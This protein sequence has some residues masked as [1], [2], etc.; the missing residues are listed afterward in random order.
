[1]AED[2]ELVSL[3]RGSIG[4]VLNFLLTCEEE[5]SKS[6]IARGADVTFK[7][8]SDIWPFLERHEIIVHTRTIG[9]AKMYSLNKDNRIVG[10]LRKIKH[11]I[12]NHNHNNKG[13]GEIFSVYGFLLLLTLPL[14]GT[15]YFA[16]ND[17]TI[18]V[19]NESLMNITT[20]V[21]NVTNA[22]NITEILVNGTIES[23][24]IPAEEN[25]NESNASS[26]V[27]VNTSEAILNVTTTEPSNITEVSAPIIETNV[28]EI[29]Y[30]HESIVIGQRVQ[31]YRQIKTQG[32]D[33]YTVGLNLP[34]D[35]QDL[36]MIDSIGNYTL[37]NDTLTLSG[38]HDLQMSFTTSPVTVSE[39][40]LSQ[41]PYEDKVTVASNSTLHYSNI[42]VSAKIPEKAKLSIIEMLGKEIIND[43]AYNVTFI[44]TDGNGK[45]DTLTWVVP[46]LSTKEYLIQESGG[47]KIE[48]ISFDRR[49]DC[50]RCGQHKVPS[51]S[52]VNMSITASFDGTLNDVNFTDYFPINW[53]MI[54]SNGGTVESYNSSHNRISW[55]YDSITGSISQW[56]VTQ[57]TQVTHP[58]TKY[59]F[60]SELGNVQSDP[61]MVVVADPVYSMANVNIY[62]VTN[63][64]R[65]S[66]DEVICEAIVTGSGAQVPV[67]IALQYNNG[68]TGGWINVTTSNAL[69][70]S[71]LDLNPTL[72]SSKTASFN[73]TFTVLTMRTGSGNQFRCAGWNGT[74]TITNSSTF[75]MTILT[76]NLQLNLT[77]TS[78]AAVY[79]DDSNDFN[80][81]VNITTKLGNASNVGVYLQWNYSTGSDH[82][83]YNISTSSSA[84][85]YAD[86]A[87]PQYYTN[88]DNI[89]APDSQLYQI[90]AH[91]AG[92]YWFRAYSNSSVYDGSFT[93]TTSAYPLTVTT[94]PIRRVSSVTIGN[95][96]NITRGTTET[97]LYCNVSLSNSGT[98]VTGFLSLQYYNST[99]WYDLN[100]TTAY[101]PK[102]LTYDNTYGTN[103]R[104]FSAIIDDTAYRFAVFGNWTGNNYLLRCNITDQSN[105]AYNISS[106]G[107]LN[108]TAIPLNVNATTDQNPPITIY[109]D[110][111][112][113]FNLTCNVSAYDGNA[114]SVT[115][116]AQWNTSASTTWNNFTR[117]GSLQANDTNVTFSNVDTSQPDTRV[118]E[119]NATAT[120]DYW[121]RCY[122]NTSTQNGLTTNFSNAVPVTVTTAP[123]PA[124]LNV[125]YQSPANGSSQTLSQ[126]STF[127]VT[128]NVTCIGGDCGN[129]TGVLRY[130]NSA[131]LNPNTAVSNTTGAT[132]FSLIDNSLKGWWKF[133][134]GSGQYVNDS[135][136][137]GLNGTL[138]NNSGTDAQDPTRIIG[139][140]GGGLLFNGRNQYVNLTVVGNSFS[141]MQPLSVEVWAKLNN[142][143]SGPFLLQYHTTAGYYGFRLAVD[144]S[145]HPYFDW[146]S[147]GGGVIARVMANNTIGDT[148]WHHIAATDDGSTMKIYIDG[149][150]S[151]TS[152]SG[153]SVW[154]SPMYLF[155]GAF[156]PTYSAPGQWFN[157]SMDNVMVYNRALSSSEVL[158]HYYSLNDN[159]SLNPVSCG[160]MSASSTCQLSWTVNATGTIGTQYWL[161]ANFT[162]NKGN[163]IANDS[164]NFQINITTPPEP[165]VLRSITT[166]RV[167][168]ING[169]DS[170]IK[171]RVNIS[172]SQTETPSASLTRPDGTMIALGLLTYNSTSGFY[173]SNYT[174]N[175]A[176]DNAPGD[177]RIN[178]TFSG[179]SSLNYTSF[180]YFPVKGINNIGVLTSR[181]Q[182]WD[183]YR[184]EGWVQIGFAMHNMMRSAGF[185]NS[186]LL[187]PKLTEDIDLSNYSALIVS[188]LPQALWTENLTNKLRN[189]SNS[190]KLLVV[191]GNITRPMQDYIAVNYTSTQPATINVNLTRTSIANDTILA[192]PWVD[193]NYFMTIPAS[194]A[195]WPSMSEDRESLGNG[196]FSFN[197]SGSWCGYGT[198]CT[199]W[200]SVNDWTVPAYN[201]TGAQVFYNMTNAVG[202]YVGVGM[203]IN[204]SVIYSPLPLSDM[205]G[206]SSSWQY[207][208]TAIVYGQR[209]HYGEFFDVFVNLFEYMLSKNDSSPRSW[210][211][212]EEA[213]AL[214]TMRHDDDFSPYPTESEFMNNSDLNHSINN[215]WMGYYNTS[216]AAGQ[217]ETWTSKGNE[218]GYHVKEGG[219]QALKQTYLQGIENN[220]S[221]TV[222]SYGDHG[223][224]SNERGIGMLLGKMALQHG[225]GAALSSGYLVDGAGSQH[226]SGFL[227]DHQFVWWNNS[228]YDVSLYSPYGTKFYMMPYRQSAGGGVYWNASDPCGMR[229]PLDGDGVYG[230]YYYRRAYYY[231]MLV[232]PQDNLSTDAAGQQTAYLKMAACMSNR[233]GV[234]GNYTFKRYAD[235]L[236]LRGNVTLYVNSSDANSLS[237]IV[238]SPTLVENFTWVIPWKAGWNTTN[239]NITI[240]G[241]DKTSASRIQNASLYNNTKDYLMF[242]TNVSAGQSTITVEK[243]IV[244]PPAA[245]LYNVSIGNV[246]NIYR[247]DTDRDIFCNATSQY[248]DVTANITLQ[249]NNSGT[250]INLN[251]TNLAT[252]YNVTYKNDYGTN[253]RWNEIVSPTGKVVRFAVYAN[254]S[255]T[256]QFRCN[257]STGAVASPTESNISALNTMAIL[258]PPLN[259]SITTVPSGPITIYNDES[260]NFNLT[261]NVSTL[262]GNA[263]SV[264]VYAQY[265]SSTAPGTWTNMTTGT[266]LKANESSPINLIN[267]DN[268]ADQRVFRIN[269]T[270]VGSYS[271]RCYAN[272]SAQSGSNVNWT[273]MVAVS[274][275]EP[276]AFKSLL[277][278]KL[279]YIN[280]TDQAM[281]VRV[282]ITGSTTE[283]VYGGVIRPSGSY[284]NIGQLQYNS[285]S[286]FYETNYT[287]N[288]NLDNLP[289]DYRV[290]VTWSGN[291]YIN[292]TSFLYMPVQGI[293]NIGVL[294][295]RTQIWDAYRSQNLTQIGFAMHELMR[296]AGYLN[297][298]MLSPKLVE[299]ADLSNFSVLIVSHLPLSL[300]TENLTNKLRNFSNEGKLLILFGNISS[301]MYEYVGV[302]Y[303]GSMDPDVGFNLT[304]NAIANSTVL[305]T[306]L[307]DTD[308]RYYTGTADGGGIGTFSFNVSKSFCQWNGSQCLTY[309]AVN[310]WPAYLYNTT[311]APVMYNLTDNAGVFK[312]VG[313]VVNGTVIYSPLPMSDLFGESA[314]WAYN[315]TRMMLG[316]MNN[317]A[318]LFEVLMRIMDYKMSQNDTF[319]KSWLFPEEAYI[320]VTLRHDDACSSDCG[321][322]NNTNM[323]YGFTGSTW[324]MFSNIS[325]TTAQASIYLAEGNEIAYHSHNSLLNQSLDLIGMENAYG[326]TI[327]TI[328]DH[329]DG[330]NDHG[331]DSLLNK[332]TYVH[333]PNAAI[334]KGYQVEGSNTISYTGGF[335]Q[336][337]LFVWWNTTTWDVTLY[338]RLR[339]QAYD[340]SVG[341][342]VGLNNSEPTGLTPTY[343]ESPR[344][345]QRRNYPFVQLVHPEDVLGN[346]TAYDNMV[347]WFASWPG[348]N[349]NYTHKRLNDWYEARANVTYYINVS[350]STEVSFVVKSPILVENFTWIT[351][352]KTDWNTA[353]INI[354]INGADKT[355]ASKI[356]NAS[357]YNGSKDYLMF[358]TNVSAGQSTIIVSKPGAG[359]LYNVTI[360]NVSNIYRGDIDND[361]FCNATSINGNVYANV[362]LQYNNGSIGGWINLNETNKANNVSYI[363]THGTNPSWGDT[364]TTTGT[365]VSFDIYGNR[366]GSGNQFRCNVTLGSAGNLSSNAT[367]TILAPNLQLNLTNTSTATVYADDSNEFNITVNISTQ[368]GN[369][370]NVGV[371][372]QYNTS[373]DNTW[374]NITTTAT[375]ALY[376]DTATPKYYAN[377]DNSTPQDSQLY[378]I[379][380]H[381][382]G[383]YWFR[384]YSN[385]SV[386]DGS[387]TNTTSAYPLTVSATP[388][389]TPPSISNWL[390]NVTNATNYSSTQGYQFN[391]TVIDAGTGVSYVWVEQNFTGTLANVTVTSCG[392]NVYCYNVSPLA[393][394]TTSYYMKWYANDSSSN[395]NL[396]SSDYV[397]YYRVN[398][399]YIPLTLYINGTNGDNTL[400]NY[401]TANFTANFSS[402]YSFN[403]TLYTNL[404]GAW[405]LWDNHVSPLTNYTALSPYVARTGYLIIA[406]FSN[407]NYTYSQAN[408]SLTL[409]Y[410]DNVQPNI[411]SFKYNV[412]N[413]TNYSSAQ[414]YQF[415]ATVTD[416]IAVD[417]VW[418][419]HNFTGSMANY[420]VTTVLGSEYYY[421]YQ[422]LAAGAYYVKWWANDTNNQVNSSDY[423]KY[424]QVNKSYI[425]LTLYIN[426]TN[427]DTSLYNNSNANFT[428]NFSAG[429]SL[430][431]TL[432]TNLTGS[433]ALWDTQNSP[434]ANYTVLSPYQ[435][436]AYLII[437]NFSNQNYT[438]TQAN[439]SLTLTFVSLGNATIVAFNYPNDGT[440][441]ATTQVI[442]FG[443]TPTFYGGNI[444]NCSLYTNR[445]GTWAWTAPNASAITNASLNAIVY[446]FDM[447]GTF[448]WSI[449]CW[450]Q[451]QLNFTNGNRTLTI[452]VPAPVGSISVTYL[453][454]PSPSSQMILQNVS[455][456]VTVNVN[457]SIGDC[458]YVNATMLYNAS[459]SN[460]D[461]A[462]SGT[463]FN[464]SYGNVIM[465]PS[466]YTN[467]GINLWQTPWNATRYLKDD[468]D[469]A[470]VPFAY[471]NASANDWSFLN[472]TY[473]N[474]GNSSATTL[475]WRFDANVGSGGQWQIMLKNFSSS[476]WVTLLNGTATWTNGLNRTSISTANGTIGPNGDVVISF[477]AYSSS[478]A[479]KVYHNFLNT[480][481][482]SNTVNCGYMQQNQNCSVA[483]YVN[484]TGAG[485][486]NLSAIFVANTTTPTTSSGNF[487]VNITTN[488][489]GTTT[490]SYGT[491]MPIE[492]LNFY[493]QG[494]FWVFFNMNNLTEYYVTSTDGMTWSARTAIVPSEGRISQAGFS[495]WTNG[496]TIDYARGYGNESDGLHYRRGTLNS[497]GS[498]SWMAEQ[499][500]DTGKIAF[501]D[502]TI[503]VDSRGYPWI[504]SYSSPYCVIYTYLVNSTVFKSS[505][506]DGTWTTDVTYN[507]TNTSYLP[508]PLPLQNGNV[509]I[510]HGF[511]HVYYPGGIDNVI[512]NGTGFGALENA[513]VSNVSNGYFAR[514][515]AVAVG[516][517]V[518]LVFLN[519]SNGQI[520]YVKRTWGSGWGTEQVL[521]VTSDDSSSPTLT[522]GPA[523]DLYVTWCDNLNNIYYMV[524]NHTTSSWASA[525]TLL[526]HDNSGFPTNDRQ[527]VFYSVTNK[528]LGVEYLKNTVPYTV[529]FAY[530][531]VSNYPGWLNISYQSP[532]TG[533]SQ[534]VNQYST[535]NIVMNVVCVDGDCGNINGTLRYNNSAGISPDTNIS[536]TIGVTPFYVMP[537]LETNIWSEPVRIMSTA[538]GDVNNDGKNEIAVGTD[539]SNYNTTMVY[540]NT[541]GGW[542][543]T[544]I[545]YLSNGDSA[546]VI[547]DANNDG[548]NDLVVE[549]NLPPVF[550]A[551]SNSTRMYENKS[552]GWIQ[553]IIKNSMNPAQALSVGDA[554]NDGKNDVVVGFDM[555][556]FNPMP[557][558][559]RMYTNASGGWQETNI[560]DTGVMIWSTQIGDGDNDNKNEVFVGLTDTDSN[561]KLRMYKNTTGKWVET[562]ISNISNT[563]NGVNSIAIGDANNDGKNDVVV[564]TNG[565]RMYENKSGGWTETN[566]TTVVPHSV[567]IGDINNDGK[568]EIAIGVY[569]QS[570]FTNEVRYYQNKSGG[571]VETNM[572]DV[573]TSGVLS[574]S[575]GDPNNDGRKELVL[576]LET[577]ANQ[578]RM[579]SASI[580]PVY[581][582]NLTANQ[583]CQVTWV[584][585]ATGVVGTQY[586]LDSNFTSDSASVP[587]NDSGNFQINITS[588]AIT[589][590]PVSPANG[591]IVDRDSV[592]VNTAEVLNLTVYTTASS[593][594]NI[595]FKANLTSPSV[596]GQTNIVLGYN[597]TNSSGG[598]RL[599]WKPNVSYY[600]G[601][602]TWWAEA[603]VSYVGNGTMTLL[604]YGGL[605]LTFQ[606]L[607]NSPDSSYVLGQ[608]VTINA[609]LRSLGPE[610]VLQ[611]NTSYLAKV[612]S[613]II[614]EDST[615]RLAYL[616][617]STTM[618]G[619]WTGNYTLA[620]G[621]PLSGNPYNVSLNASANYFFTNTTNFTR[622]FDV[623]TNVTVSITF[624]QVPIDYG[625]QFPGMTV[626]AT[627]GNG[628]PM[629]I[630][631]DSITNVNTD[632][633]IKS[634]ETNMTGNTYQQEILVQN[635][636]FAN[637]SQGSTNKTLSTGYQLLKNNIPTN[638]TDGTN[639]SA[640]WWMYIPQTVVPDTYQNHIVI[641][642]NQSA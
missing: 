304:R 327:Y 458:K 588:G 455:V 107:T 337:P 129:V 196:T 189:F 263:S 74:T 330:F 269:G 308:Y 372:L 409:Q 612:N 181:T 545:S 275:V 442:K 116:F 123:T 157:G 344:Y 268:T 258:A 371:Y 83:W 446:N 38:D 481:Q 340:S 121:V 540:Q 570:G 359:T 546:I 405:T 245:S 598:T 566:I 24:T 614:A 193:T 474:V 526:T 447:N 377:V 101:L 465:R 43:P 367:M 126:Y 31:W 582:N 434:L 426:G 477:G 61:W 46:Q 328:S 423:I 618:F 619:N 547:G 379:S 168:Y 332:L 256:A 500:V 42:P 183:A 522:A 335:R 217:V 106:T 223:D 210:Y 592:D 294:T 99:A 552:G 506:N 634:N 247:G 122:A 551:A 182:I 626:N 568:N 115:M 492:H 100:T 472:F 541:S 274:V 502:P 603:N 636:T 572:S 317:Y 1:M 96:S 220:F 339:I 602:Y 278:D 521:N 453:N 333:G 213:Y 369:A 451:T 605:N 246:S 562:N 270:T 314:S 49:L 430:P 516:N 331:I 622:A 257:V 561:W 549:D 641:V 50:D 131:G 144:T 418:I 186:Y 225:P 417:D 267:I 160:N 513:S 134:E 478:T 222:Y 534:N 301:N 63:T 529:A 509:S 253:P 410:W 362:S 376:A 583:N 520:V 364:I 536:M 620:A 391:A 125:S 130:N 252:G 542:V 399:S 370:S 242:M 261:C 390:F 425:P 79:A 353:N 311:G 437:A 336:D 51:E 439:H 443:Y 416:N 305:P 296:Q 621:D 419:E 435:A 176:T 512:W 146:T 497:D 139:K 600:A 141:G 523:G 177:Y 394:N 7:T 432:Y 81:T 501:C 229:F 98:G 350:N 224:G 594:V 312:G 556:V 499:V 466:S 187:S 424:Y 135:S 484:A 373:A 227:S 262:A 433:W 70:V 251:E 300:W 203:V 525:P 584:V 133:D 395:H 35:Y 55:H 59:D 560:S 215:M 406:N 577:A 610:S 363:A 559:L 238:N 283:T 616:N 642:A 388:D 233:P 538:V 533:N 303:N 118:F 310:R 515:S 380:A 349:G 414:G 615:T 459:T 285:S 632:I 173:E 255:G 386:Y 254:W 180:L 14:L 378:K 387:F 95:V 32:G 462:I 290:N 608:N 39:Q 412:T 239:I 473:T 298:Y 276:L 597:T 175:S 112:N 347:G 383:T 266:A 73:T 165:I 543:E 527:N 318:N 400:Y 86:I 20:L 544:N 609:T 457:C 151:N 630:R 192:E 528:V 441:N 199:S 27:E 493:A 85:L 514:F 365:I 313:L 454:Q 179:G 153:T 195:A 34:P 204:N 450:D 319:V 366:T 105:A 75:S 214:V 589:V 496:T 385:S 557:N 401:S 482:S 393:A 581:C 348:V 436:R 611:L 19:S 279:Y 638:F 142:T 149:N 136:L 4:K 103:P 485:N 33:N 532:A 463:P 322:M 289:G 503:A 601:N 48:G 172:G 15:V 445:T 564:A 604:V 58:T 591:T 29:A 635:V 456:P 23:I 421:N 408:H 94:P 221:I 21:S 407:S 108:V 323:K 422:P 518:H 159:N 431:I 491:R 89:S 56:Y 65:G 286:G 469:G 315:N 633:Y 625:N 232:H 68:S 415:N 152:S 226:W 80:I 606:S 440:T 102:N 191:F 53:P 185:M 404:T 284:V 479:M 248:G 93:N 76:P 639:V 148:M 155:L 78:T 384:A 184:S 9:M 140:S 569:S 30:R 325:L 272:S 396:N 228:N 104:N 41:N 640:Y 596:G 113:N 236:N 334:S 524:Y 16:S 467:G 90:S 243:I 571:W 563:A 548:K 329:G 375:N 519:K 137:N 249:Y 235:W 398:K 287:F 613:T 488:G 511:S 471:V 343:Q 586:W 554:N 124:F 617:Y 587:A 360:G 237:Y 82:T 211:Y 117:S 480:T 64:Y 507:T 3:F 54:D 208:D 555:D 10:Q 449:G 143:V 154:S 292:Y 579:D 97:D 595:T 389:I 483:F 207:N 578:L 271:V 575:L 147:S 244:V 88:V 44:D 623:I 18:N 145:G 574:I 537:S 128:M 345:Y 448:I 8:V 476:T 156:R 346:T 288:A 231:V 374:N 230:S 452:G 297:S 132:P 295:S 170:S 624:F 36:A 57:A 428:A 306:P 326:I 92:T 558:N 368:F 202:S 2:L 357:L 178:V 352:W 250:W 40:V 593:T 17:S 119:I 309:Y 461:T 281:K 504:G 355:A 580:N 166:D 26:V 212:P 402:S 576:G 277:T 438:Y 495:V 109:S 381:T 260:N 219:T 627:V 460:P 535:F 320:I 241:A 413:S 392:T 67:S 361:I 403:I 427:G 150:L 486:Y 505:T 209:N 307:L 293:N 60:V 218:I 240:N 321:A 573:P 69:N 158:Q 162:S 198:S 52:P 498:I 200:L 420:T 342:G 138:G 607:T 12:T 11:E 397:H 464:V 5:N 206:E 161:D 637:N 45:A 494:R 567:A 62:N 22:S 444:A 470:G 259:T 585:N 216:F 338:P 631:V 197:T 77:N 553:T 590:S 487:Q 265:N 25:T 71:E 475:Y 382:I 531:N 411:M 489:I 84:A 299:D 316:E 354:F 188:Y 490:E 508:I 628:F 190:G 324:I 111:S 539:A 599:Y 72:P 91:T 429:Y 120:G 341:G 280:G 47:K 174:L 510:V 114:T 87:T 530:I 66:Y 291:N 127:N 234:N 517:D 565:V 468:Y 302:K 205:F 550:T 356:I 282:N 264:T 37:K 169:T 273:G 163:V 28:E 164:G 358:M 171:I 6:D 167:Y 351:P 201:T 194:G 629:I 110:Q 13:L